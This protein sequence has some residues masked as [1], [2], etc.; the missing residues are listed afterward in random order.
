M[1]AIE[2]ENRNDVENG[3]VTGEIRKGFMW[4]NEVLRLAEVKVNKIDASPSVEI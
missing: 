4:E 3:I 2:I 1:R